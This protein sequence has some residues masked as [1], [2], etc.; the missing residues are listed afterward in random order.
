M[1]VLRRR[2]R[3][4]PPLVVGD[5]WLANAGDAAI[6]LAMAASLRHA[7]P[8]V[9]VA[10][11]CH[12]RA[13]VGHHYPALA[14]EPP[15]DALV[16][17]D[18]RWLS[19][20]DR[21]GADRARALVDGAALVVASGGGY[22]YEHYG[23]ERR[24]E[25]FERV[26]EHG[27][28]LAL[29][30]QSIGAPRDSV[31]RAR[32]AAILDAATLVLVRDEASLAAVHALGVR[33][34]VHRTADEAVLL[35]A[36]A[37]RHREPGALLVCASVHPWSQGQA[38][39]VP[40]EEELA[41][42]GAALER[43]LIAGTVS[44]V[45]LASTV[46]GHGGP[47]LA[48]E[49]DQ[50]AATRVREAVSPPVRERVHIAQGHLDARAFLALVAQ[51]DLAISMRMHGALLAAV[52][53]TPVLLAN[54]ADKARAVLGAAQDGIAAI[55]GVEELATVDDWLARTAANRPAALRAQ[56]AALERLRAAAAGN[57]PLLADAYR[58]ALAVGR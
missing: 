25:V 5:V 12:Q 30:A 1:R 10:F 17:D 28:P 51:H 2:R 44:R 38:V 52:A 22:L 46:Q 37:T 48:L 15:L 24:L 57:V 7:L 50:L 56:E 42:L 16:G 34:Q 29:F 41:A 18:G 6:A 23:M 14:P 11:C 33:E 9:D 45:T 32:L 19:T 36:P 47:Q 26:L 43:A 35:R 39:L 54:A 13:L 8:D 27:R 4:P 3:R 53:G 31:V 20:T 21:R 55:H 40:G 49:D 58:E